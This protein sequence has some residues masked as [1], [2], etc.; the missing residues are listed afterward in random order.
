MRVNWLLRFEQ[1]VVQQVQRSRVGPPAADVTGN[2]PPWGGGRPPTPSREAPAT[3]FDPPS[4]GHVMPPQGTPPAAG[5]RPHL[6]ALGLHLTPGSVDKQK[7]ANTASD[8]V[9]SDRDVSSAD[10]GWRSNRV[11]NTNARD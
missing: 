7:S 10:A 5:H 2:G 4:G 11:A 3:A 9:N 1:E 6:D 8:E